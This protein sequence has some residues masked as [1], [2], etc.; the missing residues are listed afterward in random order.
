MNGNTITSGGVAAG[1]DM[2]IALVA[3]LH[4]EYRAQC[5]AT[6]MEYEW[7]QNADWDPF[8]KAAGIA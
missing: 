4:G 5:L 7:H 2:A 3:R 8:T 1:M 6:I